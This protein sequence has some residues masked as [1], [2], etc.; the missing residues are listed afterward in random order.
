MSKLIEKLNKLTKNESASMGFRREKS[1]SPGKKMQLIAVLSGEK[2]GSVSGADAVLYE[3]AGNGMTAKSV[4]EDISWGGY[5]REGGEKEVTRLKDEGCDFIVFSAADAPLA[6]AEEKDIGK[7]LEI[8]TSLSDGVLRT[9]PE[10]P[11]DAVLVS[12]TQAKNQPMTYQDLMLIQRFGGIPGKPLITRIPVK[13]SGAE[14]LALWEAGVYAVAVEGNTDKLRK[15][16]EKTDFKSKGKH[17]R[18]DPVLR[19]SGNTQ[20][21]PEAPEDPDEFDRR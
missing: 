21:M 9:I 14:L 20:S 11:V 16:I 12:V 10:M 1:A 18:I 19:Q 15:E 5:L 8:D 2:E 13:V 7:I 17:D 4:P 3:T 6:L